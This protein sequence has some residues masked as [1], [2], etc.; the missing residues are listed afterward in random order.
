[1]EFFVSFFH[2]AADTR[3]RDSMLLRDLRQ[4]QPGAAIIND[5]LTI[6]IQP[7]TPDLPTF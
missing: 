7:C 4:T 1:M 2:Q 6:H 5:L 3:P